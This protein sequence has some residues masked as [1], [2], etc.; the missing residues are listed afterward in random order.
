MM[1]IQKLLDSREIPLSNLSILNDLPTGWKVVKLGDEKI[2]FTSSGGTPNRSMPKYFGGNILWVKSGELNDSWIYDTEEKIT[3]EGLKNSSA[4]KLPS[5]TLLVAMYGA[6]AGKTGILAAEATINQAICAIIPQNHSFDSQFLQFYLMLVR[7]KLLSARSGGAQPNI[8]QRIVNSL[9]VILPPLPEQRSIALTLQTIQKAIYA[10]RDELELERERKAALMEYLLTH[11]T[12]GETT[13]QTE[14]GEM[15]ESWK[16]VQLGEILREPLKN[17]H[18]ARESNTDEGIRT[19]TLTSV[20]QNN[21]CME[22]TKLTIAEPNKVRDLWLKPRDIFI[23]RANT[24]EFVGLAALYE[25]PENF[26]IYPDLLIRVR[27]KE[28]SMIPRFAIEFLLSDICR[29]YFRKNATGTAGNMPKIDQGTVYRTLM[30]FPPIAEQNEIAKV[31]YACEVKIASLNQEILL[32]KELLE[33][34]LEELMT[35]RLSTL[36]LIE[37]GETHE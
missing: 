1:S 16:V 25:G 26:A 14:I 30:P 2:A 15:P 29:T 31:A 37:E 33:T 22:N 3:E 36:P 24:L 34:L 28:E 12:H 19:L 9:E 10:R 18:S 4:R 5:G 8:N 13:K 27:L 7:P 11:G 17:G 32:L 20:T 6:T 35:G 21:F 23:E